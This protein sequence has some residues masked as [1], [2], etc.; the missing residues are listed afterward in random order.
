[1]TTT[2]DLD[3]RVLGLLDEHALA[4]VV[5]ALADYCAREAAVQHG[6]D[7]RRDARRW[8]RLACEMQNMADDVRFAG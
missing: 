8:S 3:A 1:M 5:A 2:P 6:E 7:R 4:D